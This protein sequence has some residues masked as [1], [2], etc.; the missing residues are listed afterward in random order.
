MQ[1]EKTNE[2][3]GFIGAGLMGHGMAMNIGKNGYPLAVIANKNRAPIEDLVSRGASEVKTLAQLAAESD[4]I[5]LCV[6][7]SPQVEAIVLGEDGIAANGREGMVVV[8]TGTSAP[9]STRM[10]NKKLR[11]K[12]ILFCDS[13]LS[14]TPAAA[15]AGTLISIT[16]AEK[17]LL[18]RISPVLESYSELV[19]H[20]GEAIGRGHELKLLNNFLATGYAAIWAE[21]Y[22]ACIASG[23]DPKVMHEM[24]VAG[25]GNDCPNFRNFSK[26]PLNGD[27]ESHKFAIANCAKDMDYYIRFS[28]D[29]GHGTIVSDGVRQLYKLAAAAG[30]GEDYVPALTR[31]VRQLNGGTMK[32]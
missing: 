28:D 3:I 10:I 24:V 1:N 30:C 13:P 4:I 17:P 32:E 14:R 6:S 25:G 9:A 23:N 29:L 26:F 12:G 8:D 18:A 16:A 20:V 11:A 19:M 22:S 27:A 31:F 15:E 2:R 21:A 7:S 5:F